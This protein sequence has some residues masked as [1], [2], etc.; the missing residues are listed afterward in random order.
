GNRSTPPTLAKIIVRIPSAPGLTNGRLRSPAATSWQRVQ[1]TAKA[2]SN[3]MKACGIPADI[4]GIA[5]SA[6]R[7]SWDAIVE[8]HMRRTTIWFVAILA[9][10]AAAASSLLYAQ[11]VAGYYAQRNP[12]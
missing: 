8:E 4:C 11:F 6:K 3:L 2:T 5:S 9:G 1:R 7:Q 10:F 12:G